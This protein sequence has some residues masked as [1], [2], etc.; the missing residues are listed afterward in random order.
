MKPAAA[1]APVQAPAEAELVVRPYRS[2]DKRSNTVSPRGNVPDWP[3]RLLATGGPGCGKTSSILNII[4]AS[5]QVGGPVTKVIVI[6]LDENTRE[7][8][9]LRPDKVIG[10]AELK[11]P[12]GE[13]LIPSIK[14]FDNSQRNLVI[15][16]E[17]DMGA[18][19]KA[20]HSKL[21]SLFRFAS[22]HGNMSLCFGYQSFCH[23]PKEVRDCVDSYILFRSSN[24]ADWPLLAQRVGI[25]TDQFIEL[26]QH[27]LVAKYDSLSVWKDRPVESPFALRI[28][29]FG[30]ICRKSVA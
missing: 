25:P 30:P 2:I 16:E 13:D 20:V 10:L 21:L 29:L 17:L 1:Q 6:H 24:R 12:G 23:T 19:P 26:L 28:N 11:A 22:S 8:D 14:D 3:F 27:H 4:R 15:I 18:L 5:A 9:A 7:F